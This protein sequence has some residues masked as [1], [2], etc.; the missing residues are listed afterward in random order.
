MC[1]QLVNP[2]IYLT[3]L[4][5]HFKRN[6]LTLNALSK[7]FY[8]NCLMQNIFIIGVNMSHETEFPLKKTNQQKLSLAF[9]ALNWV[10]SGL[11]KFYGTGYAWGEY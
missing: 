5:T 9:P 4:I 2:Y 6:I 3:D 8:E 7:G 1:T 10:V 11:M